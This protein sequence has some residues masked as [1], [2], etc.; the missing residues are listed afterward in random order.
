MMPGRRKEQGFSRRSGNTGVSA[1]VT[2]PNGGAFRDAENWE[3]YVKTFLVVSLAEHLRP[4]E[5]LT[6]AD[7]NT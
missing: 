6:L 5:L 4:L 1:V 2:V 7:R 3:R